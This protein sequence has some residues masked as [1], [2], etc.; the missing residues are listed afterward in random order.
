MLSPRAFG[1]CHLC[2]KLYDFPTGQMSQPFL[3]LP[4]VSPSLFLAFCLFQTKGKELSSEEVEKGFHGER[5]P[6]VV[7]PT[8]DL[9]E[10]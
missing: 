4:L 2:P 6:S 1:F 9:Q 10:G 3:K 7:V 5:L 8:N